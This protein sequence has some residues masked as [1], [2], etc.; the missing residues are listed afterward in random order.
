MESIHKILETPC[1]TPSP[2]P[3]IFE[4]SKEA[5]LHNS[6][7][8]QTHNYDMT[9]VIGAH[10]NSN[11]SYG[12]EFRSVT[13]LAP[14]L[15]RSPFWNDIK[16]SLS[17]G[18]R[19]PLERISN[20][21]RRSDLEEA[22]TR[23]NHESAKANTPVLTKLLKK[24]V[25]LAF[26]LPVTIDAIR[27]VPHACIAP[28]GLISQQS[29]DE[30]GE[31][32]TKYRA[33]H[34]Q[35]FQF[36]SRNSVNDR[37]KRDQLLDLIY[38]DMLRRII[39][40]IHSLRF[41]HPTKIILIGKYDFTSAYRRLTFWGHSAAASSSI[42]DDIGLI[43]LRLTFGGSPCPFLWCPIAETITDLAND[44][45][46]YE[47]WDVETTHSPHISKIPEPLILNDDIPFS[48]A[49]QADVHVP[50]LPHGKVDGYIDD[51]IPVV[52]HE[53]DNARRAANAVPLAMYI[54]G[55]P[56]NPD[57][58]INREDLLSF[59]KLA[60]EGQM[61]EIKTVTG[62]E[63]DS[64]RFKVKLTKD[65]FDVWSKSISTIISSSKT[66]HKSMETLE[67]RLNHCGYIIPLARHFLHSIRNLTYRCRNQSSVQINPK[68][69]KYLNLWLKFLHQAHTGI[70]INNIV[71][72]RPT[73]I[74]WDD[75]CP[76]G[77]GGVSL[78][79]RAYRYNLPR[80]LQGRVSNNALEFLASLVGCWVDILEGQVP[81]E[82]C[83]LANTDSSC[84][85]GWIYKSNFQTIDHSFHSDI[86]ELLATLFMEAQSTIFSQHFKGIWN[87]IA[88]S[89]SRDFHLSDSQLT[90]LLK[91]FSPLQVP[92]SFLI[93]PL[94]PT[95]TSWINS[96]LQ[97]LPEKLPEHPEQMP[98]SIGRGKDGNFFSSI[99]SLS[100]TNSS[101]TSPPPTES[102]SSEPLPKPSEN[103]SFPQRVKLT[104]KAACA[105]R[106]WT[107]WL[108][109]SGQ[110]IG[111]TPAMVHTT[112]KTTTFASNT[113]DMPTRTLPPSNKRH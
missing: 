1:P 10:L 44:I 38:G 24:D 70:S 80:H 4:L 96:K 110:T 18:A 93:S 50:P 85:L 72:R 89:L 9:R 62:W 111:A 76:I 100:T 66:N 14:L 16:S 104:Y 13:T 31:I 52:L 86:A 71:F 5:A 2:T 26:Q 43:S 77:I 102:E 94:P 36:S 99:S 22:I 90:I 23:G 48:P 11:I 20:S 37:V 57:E 47:D 61:A 40:Y 69:L 46:E 59:R 109:P 64:R 68:E 101:T 7:I 39:H 25:N 78:T 97:E 15:H 106:P 34:D 95:I 108:R 56:L 6:S 30:L 63:I 88:D 83:Y 21:R 17:K 75:S 91:H 53:G 54:L 87:V 74:R 35:S 51:L 73:H 84:C 103:E 81:P 8:L 49:F 107:K 29:I 113:E 12:S 79:G 65:K 32:L 60:G 55:R 112:K 45:L 42:I 33:A 27:K 92:K 82:S 28:Y 105:K 58:P 98:S 67:G 41:H 3:F 19:Y